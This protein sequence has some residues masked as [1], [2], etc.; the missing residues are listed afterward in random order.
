VQ[1]R[2]ADFPDDHVRTGSI[3]KREIGAQ[4]A[5]SYIGDYWRPPIQ[6]S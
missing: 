5:M 4:P 6:W 1:Q 3:R 2:L